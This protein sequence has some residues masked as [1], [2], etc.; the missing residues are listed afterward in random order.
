MVQFAIISAFETKTLKSFLFLT[1]NANWF[2]SSLFSYEQL[3]GDIFSSQGSKWR[4]AG[5]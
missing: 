5:Y 3:I 1:M 2:H 4:V